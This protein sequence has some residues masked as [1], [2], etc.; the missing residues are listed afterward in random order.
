MA[1]V[2]SYHTFIL[3]VVWK[4]YDDFSKTFSDFID[5]FAKNPCWD[6]Y[7]PIEENSFSKI[8]DAVSYYN[9]Y[10]YFYPQ[11]RSALYGT[12]DNIVKTY[13]FAYDKV[14]NKAHYYISKKG[15]TYDLS[16]NSI[17]VKIY[18]TGIALFIMECEN[19]GIDKDGKPQNTL[20]DVKN[21]NDYGRRIKLPFIPPVA[22]YSACADSLEV[23][24]PEMNLS[25]KADFRTFIDE[26]NSSTDKEKKISLNHLCDFIKE[27]LGWGTDY[28]FS[29]KINEDEKT[30]YL[31]PAIDD[32]M[33]VASIV[34]DKKET[35]NLL[36][37]VSQ[38]DQY[39][40]ETDKEKEKSLYEFLFVDPNED[41]TCQNS[42]MRKQLLDEHLYKRWFDYGSIYGITA[43][44]LVL[45]FNGGAMH[46]VGS[47]LTIY[48]RMACLCLAQR[49]SLMHFQNE[50]AALSRRIHEK[51]NKISVA[52]V[53]KLMDLQERF[54]AFESQI[55]FSEVTPQEQGV[56][57][58]KMFSDSFMIE[59]ELENVKSQID[60]LHDATDTYLDFNFNKIA[61]I[62]T[63]IGAVYGIEQIFT[64]QMFDSPVAWWQWLILSIIAGIVFYAGIA[65]IY[66]RKR[67]K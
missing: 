12:G 32:R 37:E 36:G 21:I 62:F 18:N 66:R 49:A 11:I 16:V 46:L 14:H 2:Y 56:E 35:D 40:F 63:F 33:F 19:Y 52:T 25:F 13:T 5:I 8:D 26:V 7:D 30:L 23:S 47:F 51:G 1:D 59:S 24:I 45:L 43:Q 54:S 60:G 17:C 31:H 9:E 58:Y 61:L 39:L 28:R 10:Q 38:Q 65:F 48:V 64:Q 29:S 57:M 34:I 55:C 67:R 15:K 41:C 50:T 3:P 27:L 4:E 20:G 42:E 6:C 22:D 44:S 53:T